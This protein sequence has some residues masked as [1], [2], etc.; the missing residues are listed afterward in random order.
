VVTEGLF[1]ERGA[2]IKVVAIE[3]VRVIVRAVL[4]DPATQKP[5]ANQIS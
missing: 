5:A 4:E 2:P 1:V 3:G